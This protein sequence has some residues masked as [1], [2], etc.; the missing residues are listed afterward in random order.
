MQENAGCV[1][2]RN[3]AKELAAD[4]GIT[5]DDVECIQNFD[6]KNFLLRVWFEGRDR[7][8]WITDL[9]VLDYNSRLGARKQQVDGKLEALLDALT[10]GG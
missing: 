3:R 2:L 7:D 4:R 8:V 1:L 9:E 5:L 10:G 6:T